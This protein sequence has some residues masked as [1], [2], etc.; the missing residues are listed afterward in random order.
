MENPAE[1]AARQVPKG[2][3]RSPAGMATVGIVG[4]GAIYYGLM[5]NDR[6]EKLSGDSQQNRLDEKL[7]PRKEGD[8]A[9]KGTDIRP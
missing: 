6:K 2:F 1:A 4:G 7:H 9:A 8:K 5:R 3:F